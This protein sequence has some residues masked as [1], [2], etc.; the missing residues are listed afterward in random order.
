MIYYAGWV[1]TVRF[2]YV[3]GAT[4]LLPSS[5]V[6]LLVYSQLPAQTSLDLSIV[7]QFSI[8]KMKIESGL[9]LLNL[10]SSKKATE[11][12]Y[13][14]LGGATQN[15]LVS[16]ILKQNNFAPGIFVSLKVN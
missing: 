2:H 7:K 15:L 11:I 16:S 9:M 3:S 14:K 10:M 5:K 12:K 8:G 6:N 13:F 1:A 4:C